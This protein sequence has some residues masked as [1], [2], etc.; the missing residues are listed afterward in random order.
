M[1]PSISS[2]S[3]SRPSEAVALGTLARNVVALFGVELG[4]VVGG[5]HRCTRSRFGGA[6]QISRVALIA[7]IDS[8]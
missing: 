3:N 5:G 8:A 1:V 2:R 4:E 6:S 7:R